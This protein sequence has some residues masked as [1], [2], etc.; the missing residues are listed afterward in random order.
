MPSLLVPVLSLF[1]LGTEGLA[2]PPPY[3]LSRRREPGPC[4]PDACYEVIDASACWN[5]VIMGAV[6]DPT[7]IYNCTAGG[8]AEVRRG[9]YH[10]PVAHFLGWLGGSHDLRWRGVRCA[11]QS[12]TDTVTYALPGHG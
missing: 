2:T 12:T 11:G 1:L 9:S 8:K 5:A 6:S 3:P 10:V 4:D 7:V